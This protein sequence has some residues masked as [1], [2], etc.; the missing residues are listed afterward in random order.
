MLRLRDSFG[1]P[2]F[3][4]RRGPLVVSLCG[5]F[6]KPEMQSLY[7]QITHLHRWRTLVFTEVVQNADLFPYPAV[8]I[9]ERRWRV[10]GRGNFVLRFWWKHVRRTWP[11]PLALDSSARTRV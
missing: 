8:E 3:N 4:G 10:R 11:P 9:M 2:P 5:T 6:L 1:N 7:R